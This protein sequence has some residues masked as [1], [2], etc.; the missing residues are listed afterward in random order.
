M[1][2]RLLGAALAA[3]LCLSMIAPVRAAEPANMTDISGHWA[4]STISWTMEQGLF[5]GIDET[6]FAPEGSMTRGMFVTVLARLEQVSEDDYKDEYLSTLYTDVTADAWFAPS[7]NWATRYGIVNGMG[8]GSFQPDK[9][10]TREQMATMVIRYA[11]N[12]H[13]SLST[14][15]DVFD[16]EFTDLS[17]VAEYAVKPLALLQETGILN[18]FPGENDTYYFG[19]Q[20]NATRAQCATVFQRLFQSR[21]K[22]PEEDWVEPQELSLTPASASLLRGETMQLVSTVL[23]ENTTNATVTWVSLNPDVVAVDKD[24]VVTALSAGTAEIRVYTYNGLSQSCSITCKNVDGLGDESETFSQK[25]LRVFGKEYPNAF[26]ARNAYTT[27]EEADSHMV[28]VSV[29]VWDFTDGPGSEKYT[30]TVTLQVHAAMAETVK[31]IFREIYEGEEQFPIN[32]AGC[33]RYEANSEHGVGLA[34]D[35]NYNSNYYIN[36]KTGQTV[37]SHWDPENDPY[38]IPLEGDVVNAF[39]K[40]G[41]SRGFWSGGVKDYMHFSYMGT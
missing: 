33:Y 11:S 10:V 31:A 7:I 12:C 22:L 13:Y 6:T 19:P 27:K 14:V 20:E 41:Y 18:G 32:D 25:C 2:N 34:I 8:D 37:G 29:D 26:A 1:R 4:E 39:R 35:L 38:S 21:G 17:A 5:N 40:Y 3:A 30:K 16:G 28:P 36:P 23:P 9:P 15:G 24:G